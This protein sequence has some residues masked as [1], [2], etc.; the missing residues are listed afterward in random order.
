MQD[1]LD[2][3]VVTVELG[4]D[5]AAVEHQGAVADVGHLLEVG[6]DHHDGECRARAR[7]SSSA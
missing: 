3:E 4:H 6:G 2:R 1:R 7:R 5:A